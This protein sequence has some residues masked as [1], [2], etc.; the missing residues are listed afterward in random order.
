LLEVGLERADVLR[1]VGEPLEAT[2]FAHAKDALELAERGG[3]HEAKGTGSPG[4]SNMRDRVTRSLPSVHP[5]A[6]PTRI[7]SRRWTPR[8]S[9]AFRSSRDSRWTSARPSR[10]HA[11]SST[12][13]RGR[14]S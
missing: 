10:A 4:R 12:S 9:T 6:A 13:S 8:N 7:P 1:L 5:R 11:Q 2:P 14:R 3:G